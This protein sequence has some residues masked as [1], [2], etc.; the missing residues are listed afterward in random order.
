[1][2]LRNCKLCDDLFV[3]QGNPICPKCVS[4]MDG[5]FESV[6]QYIEEHPEANIGEI[7]EETGVDEKIIFRF[8][9]EGRLQLRSKNSGLTC[10]VCNTPIQ[11]GRYCEKCGSEFVKE[12]R[13]ALEGTGKLSADSKRMH[14]FDRIRKNR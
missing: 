12:M 3:Y 4:K 10:A 14:T 11:K 9:H 5:Y 1:M 7:A 6:R 13:K 8:L 2:D